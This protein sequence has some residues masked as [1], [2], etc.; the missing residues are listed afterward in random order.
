MNA[1]QQLNDA[2]TQGLMSETATDGK[3]ATEIVALANQ[4]ARRFYAAMGCVVPEG[5]R[6]DKAR[7]PQEK[8][9]WHYAEIAFE[10]LVFTELSEVLNEA[11]IED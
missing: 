3:T 8:L 9:C 1:Q 7:H 5:Y 4:M 2:L 11:E 10:S 6:F